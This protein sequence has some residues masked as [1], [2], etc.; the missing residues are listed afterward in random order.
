MP[1]AVEGTYHGFTFKG[2][3]QL[4]EHVGLSMPMLKKLLNG[5]PRECWQRK[6]D[7]YLRLQGRGPL[8]GVVAERDEIIRYIAP[9]K[10]NGML[11]ALRDVPFFL[12]RIR[13]DTA[14]LGIVDDA[15]RLLCWLERSSPPSCV[16]GARRPF[17]S[18]ER[19][20]QPDCG[21][22]CP[23]KEPS[24]SGPRSALRRETA[25]TGTALATLGIPETKT[26]DAAAV[27]AIQ[28]T[29]ERYPRHFARLL[30]ASRPLDTWIASRTKTVP[31]DAG[32]VERVH[33]AVS[34]E[35][36]FCPRGRRRRFGRLK[37]GYLF[38]DHRSRCPCAAEASDQ[39]MRA[40][41][42]SAAPPGH[43]TTGEWCRVHRLNPATILADMR[44]GRIAHVRHGRNFFVREDLAPPPRDEMV[45][46][47]FCG[48]SVMHV[49]GTHLRKHGLTVNEYR[50]Q[51]PSAPIFG[52]RWRERL[53]E[54]MTQIYME[55]GDAER[56]ARFSSGVEDQFAVHLA[57]KGLV[58]Q[59]DFLR[60]HAPLHDVPMFFDFFLPREM[61]VVE[62]D[63]PH[64]WSG[65]WIYACTKGRTPA[66]MAASQ[67]RADKA[68]DTLAHTLGYRIFRI[69]VTATLDDVEPFRR[70]LLRQDFPQHLL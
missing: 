59:I 43:V 55:M 1:A 50:R 63:G 7:E 31:D 67:R 65:N 39:Q 6:I 49:S 11:V 36:P 54:R 2:R 28:L 30:R 13:D 62:I 70:Q 44:A 68:R 53:K 42:I 69:R 4:A 56:L 12:G 32:Y 33:V 46:C 17:T 19:G 25:W 24:P 18:I 23:G 60:Q 27:Q 16:C 21:P 22:R 10:R 57:S 52:S 9:Y 45:E 48:Q 3:D 8:A 40:T 35:H 15:E 61:L 5:E 14:G 38:C 26:D 29:V 64:H 47:V 41:I 51:F 20:W 58:D 66:E 37:D 34:G